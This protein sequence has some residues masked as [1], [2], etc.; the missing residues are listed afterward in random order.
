MALALTSFRMACAVKRANLRVNLP[1]NL[2]AML[3]AVLFPLALAMQVEAA[4]GNLELVATTGEGEKSAVAEEKLGPPERNQ[5]TPRNAVYDFLMLAREGNW[6]AASAHLEAPA[7]GWPEGES[8]ERIARDTDRDY[9]LTAAEAK[10]Y[11]IIDEVIE[12][13][14]AVDNTGPIAPIAS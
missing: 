5:E 14:N 12:N 7:G 9:V 8:P 4:T 2:L 1:A 13:R 3:C 10:E 11:G 6:K